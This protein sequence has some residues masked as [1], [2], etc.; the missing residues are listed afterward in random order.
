MI[1]AL[2][3]ADCL[4]DTLG[5]LQGL[6]AQGHEVILADGGS[7]D[8]TTAI[9]L[10]LTD[11]VIQAPR[12]RAC[13]MNAGAD[14]ASGD[15]LWFLHADTRIPAQAPA[16]IMAALDGGKLWGRFDIRL[17]GAHPVLRI[18]EAAM[19]LRS[20][21]SGIATGDQGIFVTREGFHAVG[22]FPDIPLMEDIAVSKSLRA[23]ER[24][25]CLKPALTTSSRRWEK[26]GLWR[27]IVLMWRLRLA[28]ALGADPRQLARRYQ[29]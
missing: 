26:Q 16:A 3:E 13:Q 23:M 20:R 14:R 18:V 8:D 10:P 22:R 25:A 21:L 2:N 1:P 12:G 5:D 11:L 9:A 7:T 17:S 19:N 24:P 27:T 6:R 28:Y 4:A 29:G 15:V